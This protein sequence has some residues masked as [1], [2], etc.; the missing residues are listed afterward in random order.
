MNTFLTAPLI[1]VKKQRFETSSRA[2]PMRAGS[3]QAA[4]L[5]WY[6][7]SSDLELLLL[8]RSLQVSLLFSLLQ[9]LLLHA[10][11]VL[12]LL[13]RSAFIQLVYRCCYCHLYSCFRVSVGTRVE[14]TVNKFR[15]YASKQ[16]LSLRWQTL[17]WA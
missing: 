8:L 13:L 14:I 6:G 15:F 16:F 12:F 2:T 5:S 4:D 3:R 7:Y 17:P 10:L 1:T 9:Q 11:I